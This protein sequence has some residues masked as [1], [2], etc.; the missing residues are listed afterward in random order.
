MKT[1]KILII[2]IFVISALLFTA[3]M[4]VKK[5]GT[6]KNIRS[7]KVVSPF[8]SNIN[9]LS[10][11]SKISEKPRKLIY[12]Y[13]P[14]WNITKIEYLQLDKLTDIAYF[15]LYLNEYG[16]FMT[17]T[18]GE[19]GTTIIE[20]AYNNWKNSDE[21]NLLITHCKENNVRF[22]LTII[23]HDDASN[24]EFLNCRECWDNLVK[25]LRTELDRKGIRDVNLN[26]EH[27]EGT[28]EGIDKKF[29]E[30]TKY[31]NDELD[32]IYGNS[33][34]VVSAFGDSATQNRVSSDLEN[35]SRAADGIFIMAYDYH[36]PTSEE[37]GPVSPIEGPGI[38]IKETINDFL[39]KVPPNKIILGVPYYGYNWLV[40]DESQY[41]KRKDGSDENGYSQS[42][43]YEDILGTILELNPVLKWNEEGK[44]PY[45]TYVSPE[46][47]QL[48][49]TYY[50]NAKSLKYK[51]DI[52]NEYNLGGVGM[53]ALGYDGGY[54][55]LWNLLYDYFIK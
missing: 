13:L 54:T 38:D 55:E 47:G 7:S 43:S 22:A 29:S 51:Y 18:I 49:T 1:K 20:P 53:W 9:V 4:S 50:E 17:T 10:S 45:F 11:F 40:E 15:G 30:F 34:V 31:L 21:L 16:D 26:F 27:A 28:K 44:S 37:I 5:T 52:V 6:P 42:Q 12:G 3:S 25:N 32:K 39:T 33:Y 23:A 8:S 14:Y 2:S 24:D 36:Q 41:S 35:L 46:T 48:R 19:D